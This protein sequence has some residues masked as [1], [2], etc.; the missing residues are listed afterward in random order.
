GGFLKQ[1]GASIVERKMSSDDPLID[2]DSFAQIIVVTYDA[3]NH[4]LERD[5]ARQAIKLAKDRTIAVSIRNPLDLL[6]F[7]EV[8][9]YLAVYECRPLALASAAKALLGELS[10]KGRLPLEISAAY[11]FGW[12]API[13]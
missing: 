2:V 10:P 11:P 5:I 6:M 9:C 13:M 8:S 12:S 4:S 7:P 1:Y 3:S